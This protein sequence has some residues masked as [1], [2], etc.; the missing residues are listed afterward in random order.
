M[1]SE[2]LIQSIYILFLLG[3]LY[4]VK[5]GGEDYRLFLHTSCPFDGVLGR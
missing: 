1:Y 4:L 3:S 2:R 5:Q